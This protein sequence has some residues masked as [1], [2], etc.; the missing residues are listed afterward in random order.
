MF[1]QGMP[2]SGEYPL[3]SYHSST[4]TFVKVNIIYKYNV[5]DMRINMS[6]FCVQSSLTL[7]H[8]VDKTQ[9]VVLAE[10]VHTITA[11][12]KI[13]DDQNIRYYTE[14]MCVGRAALLLFWI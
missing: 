4:L 11:L 5:S 7:S 3:T 13:F 10:A 9:S 12:L 8:N 6:H 14:L 2:S 1:R